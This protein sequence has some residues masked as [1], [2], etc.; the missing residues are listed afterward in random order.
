MDIEYKEVNYGYSEK[1]FQKPQ[2]NLT[3]ILYY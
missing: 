1:S 2:M 3:L